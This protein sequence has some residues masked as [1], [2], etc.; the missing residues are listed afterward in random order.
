[1][2]SLRDELGEELQETGVLGDLEREE[3]LE[4]VVV[5]DLREQL[6]MELLAAGL[7]L[8]QSGRQDALEEVVAVV[9]RGAREE[10]LDLCRGCGRG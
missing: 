3:G 10:V 2:Q 6:Q 1:M 7:P 4:G 9:G 5:D 8:L